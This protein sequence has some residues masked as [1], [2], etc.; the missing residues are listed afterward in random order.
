MP[1][2]Q[3][4]RPWP[5]TV[6]LLLLNLRLD[7]AGFAPGD[8][9]LHPLG[10]VFDG[11]FPGIHFNANDAKTNHA[12]SPVWTK[13]FGQGFSGL[14]R[15]GDTL[16]TQFQTEAGQQ[17]CAISA[18]S[19]KTLWNHR[20]AFPWELDG[21]YSGPFGTPVI[22]Q[23]RVHFTDCFG[24]LHAVSAQDGSPLWTFDAVDATGAT[25]VDFG[26]APTPLIIQGRLY[27]PAPTGSTNSTLYCL[28]ASNGRP[29]WIAGTNKPSYASC[30]PI[31]LRDRL[32]ILMLTRNGVATFDASSGDPVWVDQWTRG[33]DEQSTWP[34]FRDPHL[35]CASPFRRGS[36]LY[37]LKSTASGIEAELVWESRSLSNDIFNSVI[38]EDHVYG[39]E[40]HSQQSVMTGQTRGE[41]VCLELKTGRKLW[42]NPGIRHCSTTVVGT[43]IML[44][45]DD[46]TLIC[47]QPD[48]AQCREIARWELPK[49]GKYWTTPHFLQD[50]VIVRNRDSL[51]CFSL[52]QPISPMSPDIAGTT[53]RDVPA[54]RTPV[55]W[56]RKF[57]TPDYITP[58][59]K[60]LTIWFFGCS[61]VMACAWSVSRALCKTENKFFVFH[62]LVI[63]MSVAGTILLS[64]ALD[65]MVFTIPAA[66][67]SALTWVLGRSVMT[68]NAAPGSGSRWLN[69]LLLSM[70]ILACWGYHRICGSLF[71]IAG[72]GFLTGL[73]VVPPM[74]AI[75]RSSN[76]A[77]QGICCNE[78]IAAWLRFG[79]A[80]W[81]SALIL[82]L[83][84]G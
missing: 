42:S 80:F 4:S 56:F 39:Y 81:I 20:Y 37:S 23:N 25:G 18:D 51:M 3:P 6:L 17:I 62:G 38:V 48:P 46:G 79:A 29:I 64:E 77:I 13:H 16:F 74:Y 59:L 73:A 27:M 36:R 54:E 43:N 47:L 50:R 28:D 9:W 76:P 40:V 32:L 22:D 63:P 12:L 78:G 68:R 71:F 1:K 30:R 84:G 10:P 31:Q 2:S 35:F 41:Y 14:T 11:R 66:L 72:W 55:G 60:T 19:G 67:V 5:V 61:G 49:G 70:F 21:R 75:S 44:L 69:S 52:T 8:D 65:T 7:A 53:G 57:R 24:S 15:K 82:R 26:Y 83:R 58:S 33:Y 34:A 45:E